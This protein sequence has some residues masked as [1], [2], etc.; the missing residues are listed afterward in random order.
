MEVVYKLQRLNVIL[1]DPFP[2]Q[3]QSGSHRYITRRISDKWQKHK[4]QLNYEI[5]P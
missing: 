2:I 5:Y 4:Y 1:T 3:V